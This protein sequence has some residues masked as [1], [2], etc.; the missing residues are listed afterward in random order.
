MRIKLAGF[1]ACLFLASS[2]AA[3]PQTDNGDALKLLD[4]V[5]RRYAD[6]TSYRIEAIKES[7][8]SSELSS[9]WHK[10]MLKAEQARGSRYRFE[11]RSSSGSGIVVSDGVT[12]WNLHRTYGQYIKRPPGTFGHPFPKT[13]FE[14]DERPEL[15]AFGLRRN[16]AT[17][18]DSVKSA[19]FLAEETI[20]IGDH[21]VTCLVVTFGPEDLRTP[22][23]YA[24]TTQTLWIDRERSI[25]VK[26]LL[27]SEG[28][29][30][31]GSLRPPAHPIPF[32]SEEVTLYPVVEL[33]EPLPD[34]DFAFT[35]SED[36]SL[37]EQFPP[38]YT[39]PAASS[40]T[41]APKLP[42][43]VGKMAQALTLHA[44]D[45]SS[46][47]LSSLHGHPVLIDLWATWCAPCLGEMPL[48]DHIFQ[49]TKGTG[50][51]VLSVD[52]DSD[53]KTAL[54][55]LKRKNYAWPNYHFDPKEPGF[56]HHGIP[57][58]VLI[59]GEGRI[60]YYYNAADDEPGL[61]SAIRQLGPAFAA[62]LDDDVKH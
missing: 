13:A 51:V 5:S 61:V 14:P 46:L 45:N 18:G 53:P 49:K 15:E 38:S 26:S 57:L 55:F 44:A 30:T 35:A 54:D 20:S 41:S 48:I 28:D 8:L 50:F 27:V 7:R 43:M 47:Q 9:S 22:F 58:L 37:V 19:H 56:P 40:P 1:I 2:L 10:E 3:P 34:A 62:A 39:P 29:Q 25:I 36:A 12:E 4:K 21:R 33:D 32:H 17:V 11:G 60:V 42:E 16:L 59:D 31:Y 24:R 52:Y 6:A 23:P